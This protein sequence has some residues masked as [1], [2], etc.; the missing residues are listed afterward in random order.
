MGNGNMQASTIQPRYPDSL[1]QALPWALLPILLLV[2]NTSDATYGQEL[3]VTTNI[4]PTTTPLLNLGTGVNSVGT[5]TQITGGTRPNNG[6]NLFHS[7]DS[8][9]LGTGDIAHFLNNLELPTTNIISRV[10]G[11][12]P[13][14]IDGTLRTNNPADVNDPMNFGAA[15]LWLVTPSGVLLG[16]NARVEVGGSVSFSTANYLRFEFEGTS[17]L[18]DMLSSPAS[19]GPLFVEPVTAFGFVGSNPGAIT[20]QGSQFSVTE[21]Q[22]ISLVG[23]KVI[24]QSGTPDGGTTQPAHL[25]AP[26]G[27]ILLASAAS[28]GEFNTAALQSLPNV[29]GTS[30]TSFGSVSLAEGSH[31]DVSGASTVFIKGGQIV[32]SVND[33][34]LTTSQT[35]SEPETIS[36]RSGSSIT[37][38]NSGANPGADVQ[39]AVGTL[40]LDSSTITTE[41]F[42]DGNGGNITADVG[43]LSLA[44]VAAI[45]SNNSSFGLGEGGNVTVQGLQG[46]GSAADAVTLDNLSIIKTE[47]FGS[48]HGGDVRVTAHKMQMDNQAE[49]RTGTFVGGGVGGD[50]TLN[51]ERLTLNGGST[52]RTIDFTFGTDSD[53]DGVPDIPSTGAGGHVTIQGLQGAGSAAESVALSAGSQIVS[54]GLDGNGGRLAILGISL[55]LDGAS[56]INSGTFGFG[57]GGDIVLSVGNASLLGGATIASRPVFFNPVAGEP[58]DITI[59]GLNGDGSK[60]DTLTLTGVRS[61]ILQDTYGTASAGDIAVYA[62]TVNM[63]EEAVIEGGTRD[64]QGTGGKVTINADSVSIASGSHISSQARFL[65]SGSVTVTANQLTLDNGSIETTTSSELPIGR[66]GDVV[67]NVG[68]GSLANGAKII[69]DTS[70]AGQGGDITMPVGTLTLTNG[71]QISSAS[72]ATAISPKL[73]GTIDSPG[74]AGNVTIAATGGF[75]SDASTVATSAEANQGG[76]IS[77]TAQSVQ[78][79]NGTLITAN[80]NGPLEVKE[81]VLIDG[82]PVDQVVGNGNAGNITIRS[83]STFVMTNSS[84]TTEA[85]F[86]SGGQITIIT[87][88][89][90]RVVN[91]RVST[92]VAGFE[93]DT[94]GGNIFIDPQ[95]VVLQGGQ[96]VAQAF[97]GSG[98]AINIVAT[99]AFIADPTSIVD[100]SSTLGISGTINI[101]SPVQNIGGELAA[102]SDEFS[103]AAALLAQQCAARAADGKFSTFV[104]AAREGVPVEPGGFLASPLLTA[105]LLGSRRSGQD[106]HTQLSA[107]TGLFP[108]YEA[109]PIQLAK[110]G[111]TCR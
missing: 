79:S 39:I 20:V 75:T 80:S 101:Q 107:I 57:R 45:S 90:V 25:S 61:G 105:E 68:S 33:A 27:K 92:S 58:G 95:F 31:I 96:I 59:R 65:A 5:T 54:E 64:G 32:L 76:D 41:T 77:I 62:K 106:P 42:G 55:K 99:S 56:S 34:V 3:E 69:S 23:G 26:N 6:T 16:P 11:T 85:R 7:F 78:L 17:A 37:T 83:G 29:D 50:L 49:V 38:S 36:L 28:T 46:L 97:A 111:G 30:F 8:F 13:S 22:N 43:M 51:V 48:G 15:N 74:R 12:E 108:K 86:A 110:F 73:D 40:N 10:I 70:G 35:P 47:T 67:L 60:A 103:S 24:I 18:F 14:T 89:M 52:I 4:T 93:K 9:T 44:N 66:G 19:F 81:K 100:A 109:Q 94:A 71:S 82:L 88:E 1:G 104:V 53:D 98:G 72:T 63:T 21:G 87:P 2:L 84:M 102:L 91:G